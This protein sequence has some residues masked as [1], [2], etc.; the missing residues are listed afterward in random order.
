VSV[1]FL[2]ATTILAYPAMAIPFREIGLPMRRLVSALSPAA[3]AT[4]V[5]TVVAL[6]ARVGSEQADLPRAGVLA[7]GVT[8]AA[9]ALLGC[10]AWQRPPALAELITAARRRFNR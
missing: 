4:V 5:M 6:G 2:V 8:A 1:G 3:I 9:V 10:M 7:I